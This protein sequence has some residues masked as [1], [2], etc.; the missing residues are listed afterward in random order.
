MQIGF[1]GCLLLTLVLIAYDYK[2][3]T[4]MCKVVLIALY[5]LVLITL[6]DAVTVEA[7]VSFMSF[8]IIH[9]SLE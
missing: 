6:L 2:Q 5:L 3:Y 9:R 1:F 4:P 8:L 7:F